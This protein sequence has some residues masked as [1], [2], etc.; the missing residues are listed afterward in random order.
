MSQVMSKIMHLIWRFTRPMTLG[1][2]AICLNEKGEVFLIKHSYVKGWHLPG[3]GVETGETFY[4]ALA[5]ELREEGNIILQGKPVLFAAYLNKKA[6][7]RDHV[8]LYVVKEF[9]QNGFPKP[10]MEIID[11][12]WFALE[13]LPQDTT[14]ATRARLKEA[15]SGQNPS[16]EW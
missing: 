15:L 4:A 9:T 6:S 1:V 11:H 5:K 13:A 8:L 16:D 14:Q 3:G 7:K 10:N 2:R 12:G